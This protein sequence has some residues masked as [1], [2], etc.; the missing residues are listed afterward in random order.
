MGFVGESTAGYQLFD[1]HLIV[2]PQS[3]IAELDG[4]PFDQLWAITQPAAAEMENTARLR[5]K[6]AYTPGFVKITPSY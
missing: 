1:F 2:F 5:Q 4:L 6:F 3:V